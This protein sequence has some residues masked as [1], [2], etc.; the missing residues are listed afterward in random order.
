DRW[1]H[2]VP[3]GRS[4]DNMRHYILD[5]TLS[6]VPP[7]FTGELHVAGHGVARCYWGSPD[8]TAERFVADP[9]GP[10]GTRM[11]RTGD[12]AR[13]TSDGQV[14]FMGR[15]D[16][17]V[18][19]RGFRIEPG[20]IEAVLGA[21]PGVTACAAVVREDRPGE[22][23]LVA[24][25]VPGEGYD[26]GNVRAHLGRNLPDYMVPTTVVE[27]TE[28]PLTMIGKLDRAALPA[29][30][31]G[32]SG[33]GRAPGTREEEIMVRLFA[34]I[35]GLTEEDVDA[36]SGF[37]DLGGDSIMAIQLVSAARRA[38]LE[39]TGT[40]VFTHR[41]PAELARAAASAATAVTEDPA[42][43]IGGLPA[44]PMMH[45][46]AERRVPT[47]RFN[48]TTVLWA[49]ADLDLP[50]LHTVIDALLERHDSLRLRVVAADPG[51]AGTWTVTVQEKGTVRAE[52]RVLR[53]DAVGL[54]DAALVDAVREH[55]AAAVD[56]LVPADGAMLSVV[57][58]DRG[59]RPGPV[60]I[61]V[62]HL[63]VD[64]VSWR[65]LLPDLFRAWHDAGTGRTPLLGVGATS[66][67]RWAHTAVR[68]VG[69]PGTRA[70]LD[71][72]T[73]VLRRGRSPLGGRPLDP[74]R[75]L[76]RSAGQLRRTLST[77]S[78]RHLLTT[79]PAVVGAG[80]DD[81]LLAGLALAAARWRGDPDARLLVDVESHGRTTDDPT[82]DLSHTTG[83]FTALYPVLLDTGGV[84]V[85]HAFASTE[86]AG[87][88][89]KHVKEQLREVPGNGLGYGRLR[90]LRP[91]TAAAFDGLGHAEVGFN[92]LGRLAV[93]DTGDWSVAGDLPR[94]AGEDPDTPMA[95]VVE[96]N[97]Y[98]EETDD[99]P[100]LG[101]SWTWAAD[102]LPESDVTALADGWFAALDAFA[103]YAQRPNAGGLTPHDVGLIEITQTEIEEFE[104]DLASD[105]EN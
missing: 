96:I 3:I 51:D 33:G 69:T 29:P 23:R 41:T 43:A 27:L 78:T 8:L 34:E 25:A 39:I 16:E 13:W 104:D 28:L 82:V 77:E 84:G 79:A 89:L 18:K 47:D 95:H 93:G 4:M 91:D 21:A 81:V 36:D 60:L 57:W 53:I 85:E 103:D 5:D 20:E 31:F 59:D 80:V 101:V 52:D 90:H 97:A 1:T 30:E 72:W 15:A 35:V 73:E 56:R 38:G 11:Y 44:S 70:E 7:G 105:W 55:G 88:V 22:K 75:D 99:G 64:G 50:R 24:Y 61:A 19:I 83:W 65:I 17:Q 63:A 14:E 54:D 86:A 26:H 42:E 68:A 100:R 71:H 10:P 46:L 32:T 2:S 45:W 66:L 48:Q 58:F 76:L 6:P 74:A 102:I 94:P 9:Y 87:S 67:R 37:F 40:D 92:Y 49:P 12:L 62:N 98:V